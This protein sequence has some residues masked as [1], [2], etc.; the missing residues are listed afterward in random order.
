[1]R[2]WPLVALAALAALVPPVQAEPVVVDVELYVISFG[3]YDANKGT[4]TMDFYLHFSHDNASAPPGFVSRFEFMNGRAASKELIVEE[5]VDGRRDVWYRIQANLF[6]PPRF[7]E[8]PYDRQAIQLVLEDSVHTDADL[9]YRWATAGTGL[10]ASI[11]VAGWRIDGTDAEVS[12]KEYPFAGATE[13]YSRLTYT[14]HVSKAPLSA[15]LRTFLPPVAFLLVASFSFFLDPAQPVPRLTL[16]TGMLISAVAFHL[17][18]VVNVP[19]LSVLT[20]FDKFMVAAYVFIAATI[21]VTTALAFGEKLRLPEAVIKVANRWGA[22]GA[23]ALPL[24]VYGL[25]WL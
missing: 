16:G 5:V 4:Y 17:S 6:S 19:L 8:F 1:M 14:I 10:D 24:L 20:P 22:V 15:T 11:E 25:M 7:A 9:V 12:T 13:T 2:A 18:Q 21:F 23:F 3:N